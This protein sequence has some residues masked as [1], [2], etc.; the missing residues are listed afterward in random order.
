ML[1]TILPAQH[2]DNEKKVKH[3][4]FSD[5][6]AIVAGS[7]LF[8]TSCAGC[9]G[10]RG[11]G[12][13]GPNLRNRGAWHS[14]D[15]TDLFQTIQKGIPGSDMPATKLPDEQIWQLAAFVRALSAPAIESKLAGD[16]AA[17]E[18]VFWGKAECGSCHRIL[19]RGGML[20]PD[21]SNVGALRPVD[22]LRE[23]ILDPDADGFRGYKGITVVT[24]AGKKIQ[25][26]ARD[27]TNYS[28]SILDKNGAVHLLSMLDVRDLQVSTHS[29]MPRDYKQ[30][31]SREEI[32]NVIAYL[33]RQSVRPYTSSTEKP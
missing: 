24:K 29:P 18:V 17:G 21:L 33:S 5:P 30:K 14:L 27:R 12:G 1:V 20:G 8:A 9:H 32:E 26:V 16:S 13:R 6:I 19:G 22:Q 15:E 2:A 28:I 3:P 4:A 31:L 7:K 11:E 10:P 25:G 23:A